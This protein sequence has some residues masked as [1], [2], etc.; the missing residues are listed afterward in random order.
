MNDNNKIL[1]SL[2]KDARKL[3]NQLAIGMVENFKKNSRT[4]EE[5]RKKYEQDEEYRDVVKPYLE[6]VS[7][8]EKFYRELKNNFW[9]G[10]RESLS[11]G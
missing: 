11:V 1:Q 6:K 10:I 4:F 2:H 3:G 9:D 8:D 5:F 7:P